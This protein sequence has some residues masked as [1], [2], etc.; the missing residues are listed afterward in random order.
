MSTTKEL[1]KNLK[2]YTKELENMETDT[3]VI[4]RVSNKLLKTPGLFPKSVLKA[5]KIATKNK[6]KLIKDI[7]N[8]QLLIQL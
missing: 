1:I 2:A 6:Q 4:D 7:E 3:K 5:I 8:H